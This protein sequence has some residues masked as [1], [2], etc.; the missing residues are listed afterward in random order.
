MMTTE[1]RVRDLH[2]RM[3]ERKRLRER[4]ITGLTGAACAVLAAFLI[5]L[6][7]SERGTYPGGPAGMYSGSVLLFEGAGAY[8]LV[9]VVAFMA[10][11]IVTVACIISKKKR[12]GEQPRFRSGFLSGIAGWIDGLR[13]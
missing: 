1:E 10:G 7:V 6:T 8:V 13:K 2:A 3:D 9:A 5:L 12:S 4:R 11:V